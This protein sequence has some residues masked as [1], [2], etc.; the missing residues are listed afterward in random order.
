MEYDNTDRGCLF[1]NDKGAN[2][3]RPD[4]KGPLNA[5]GVDGT[6]SAWWAKD[7]AGNLKKDK[8]GNPWL[9]L[10]WEPKAA[11]GGNEPPQPVSQPEYADTGIDPF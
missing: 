5:G 9:S 10:K 1:K 4:H 6:L 8:N 3:K 2:A 11:R 7:D